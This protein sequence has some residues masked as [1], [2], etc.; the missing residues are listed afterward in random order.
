MCVLI[1]QILYS[2]ETKAMAAMMVFQTKESNKI[3]L[4]FKRR[5][6]RCFNCLES[7]TRADR[8]PK[9]ADFVLHEKG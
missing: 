6:S 8:T 4:N 9:M 2:I 7:F 5:F 1:Y 3:L